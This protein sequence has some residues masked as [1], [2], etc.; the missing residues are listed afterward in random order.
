MALHRYR[1]TAKYKRANPKTGIIENTERFHEGAYTNQ[2]ACEAVLREQIKI[3]A[4]IGKVSI[5][6]KKYARLQ[7]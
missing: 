3:D 6:T 5:V 1:S 4:P 7:R 2:A